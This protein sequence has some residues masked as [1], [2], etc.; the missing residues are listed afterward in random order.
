MSESSI[1][2]LLGDT[3]FVSETLGGNDGDFIADAFIGFEVESELWVVAFNDDLCGL[4]DGLS[5]ISI[6]CSRNPEVL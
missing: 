6:I 4:L 1:V 5:S 2:I 3:D